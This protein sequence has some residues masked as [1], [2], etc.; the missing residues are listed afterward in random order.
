MWSSDR[1]ANIEAMDKGYQVVHPR[2]M[3]REKR[4][5]L[6]EL[7]GME[8]ASAHFGR[9]LGGEQDPSSR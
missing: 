4:S 9:T 3:S 7:G 8:S 2:M 6:R 5:N 1:N